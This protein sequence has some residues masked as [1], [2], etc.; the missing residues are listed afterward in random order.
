MTHQIGVHVLDL[1][2]LTIR[3]IIPAWLIDKLRD[4]SYQSIPLTK[5]LPRL[6]LNSLSAWASKVHLCRSPRLP[7]GDGWFRVVTKRQLYHGPFCML[8]LC[9]VYENLRERPKTNAK[10]DISA[11]MAPWQCTRM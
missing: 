8:G 3:L 6:G 1:V 11:H 7:R 2:A 4:K 9:C 5:S 10:L